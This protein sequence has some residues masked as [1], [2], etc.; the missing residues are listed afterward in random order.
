MDWIQYL[1]QV[2]ISVAAALV[3]GWFMTKNNQD[4][5]ENV[6]SGFMVA[7]QTQAQR[8]DGLEADI[9][10]AKQEGRAER[11]ILQTKIS[12]LE[13]V[14]TGEINQKLDLILQKV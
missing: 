12:H 4:M 11:Q 7:V 3:M 1:A 2:P 14:N 6:K 5:V 8:I 10:E 9:K 13:T